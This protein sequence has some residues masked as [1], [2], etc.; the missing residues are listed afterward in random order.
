[1]INVSLDIED[2]CNDCPFFSTETSNA[3]CCDGTHLIYVSCEHKVLCSRLVKYLD[4]RM[5]R[6]EEYK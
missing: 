2:Y 3:S 5:K 6:K 1:M 4:S